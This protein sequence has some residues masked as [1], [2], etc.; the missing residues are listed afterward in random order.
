MKQLRSLDLWAT[1]LSERD[2]EL[3]IELPALEYLSIGNYEHLP[4]LDAI[5]VV[6]LVLSIPNLRR[7]WLD[8]IRV[9]PTQLATLKA[10]LES[11]RVTSPDTDASGGR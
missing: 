2:L 4:S 11:V 8:G 5:K 3:L 6:D 9:E 7:V 1:A 10:K